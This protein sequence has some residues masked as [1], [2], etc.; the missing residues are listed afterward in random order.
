MGR[1]TITPINFYSTRAMLRLFNTLYKMGV[2]D[3]VA[4]SDI[5]Q[6]EEWIKEHYAPMTFSRIVWDYN[7]SWQ[8]WRYELSKMLKTDIFRKL[9]LRFLD[10]I[11]SYGNYYSVVFP[12]AMDFYM[13]GIKDYCSRPKES[14]LAVFL[15][16]EYMRW[17]DKRLKKID[18][19]EVVY[20]LQG[21]CFARTRVDNF[22]GKDKQGRIAIPERCYTQFSTELWRYSRTQSKKLYGKV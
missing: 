5:Y 15:A 16:T 3:A 6:C 1:Q 13:K 22:N 11:S 8:E 18:T 17:G 14:D 4:I 2:E 10:C 19:D 21:F 12:V 9:G 7:V 20:E